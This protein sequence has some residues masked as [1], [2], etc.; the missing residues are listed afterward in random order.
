MNR[1][2]LAPRSG[3]EVLTSDPDSTLITKK[4]YTDNVPETG[5]AGGSGSS[6]EF[7]PFQVKKIYYE[8][9]SAFTGISNGEYV[10]LTAQ[11]DDTENGLYIVGTGKQTTIL[12]SLPINYIFFFE[13]DDQNF[14]IV[15][16]DAYSV[17]LSKSIDVSLSITTSST[18]PLKIFDVPVY[19]ITNIQMHATAIYTTTVED[20]DVE[21]IEKFFIDKSYTL[22]TSQ[23]PHVRRKGDIGDVDCYF[24]ASAAPECYLVGKSATTITWL[25]NGKINF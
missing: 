1:T 4:Y 24:S 25:I 14:A 17:P 10:V 11:T 6:L 8:Q 16:E 9:T 21:Y 2:K 15:V 19:G 7:I 23:V 3:R 5:G 18:T 20:E 22:T 13:E 12:T